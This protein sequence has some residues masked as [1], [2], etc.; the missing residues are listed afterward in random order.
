MVNVSGGFA[1]KKRCQPVGVDLVGIYVGVHPVDTK[2]RCS[3]LPY[4]GLHLFAVL[5]KKQ[6]LVRRRCCLSVLPFEVQKK[7]K[8]NPSVVLLLLYS[9]NCVVTTTPISG[10]SPPRRQQTIPVLNPGQSVVVRLHFCEYM[11][12]GIR[13]TADIPARPRYTYHRLNNVP[14]L[15][16][17]LSK[18]FIYMPHARAASVAVGCPPNW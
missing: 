5:K 6:A 8:K 13:P 3:T 18:T 14:S 15:S 1:G 16:S 11:G 10:R 9:M 2:E 7:K 12:G 4:V 17:T